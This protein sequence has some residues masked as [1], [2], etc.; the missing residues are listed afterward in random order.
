MPSTT[1][2]STSWSLLLLIL[3]NISSR[4]TLGFHLATTAS[5]I[6]IQRNR[7]QGPFVV[8][9]MIDAEA[10]STSS[11]S[12][13][14]LQTSWNENNIFH[15]LSKNKEN[16]P[17]LIVFDLDNTLWTPELYTLRRRSNTNGI[18][19]P[20]A[21]VHV[22]LFPGALAILQQMREYRND[23]LQPQ[24]NYDS[25][26]SQSNNNDTSNHRTAEEMIQFAIASRTK[27][28]DWAHDLLHQFQIHDL[29]S[30]PPIRNNIF[31]IYMKK[32][33]YRTRI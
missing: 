31:V 8:R 12:S 21:N 29:F 33:V 18:Q 9:P 6:C 14:S 25:N 30:F 28:I 7:Q 32:V 5:S 27:S 13:H 15:A 26:N 20:L 16:I 3:F 24:G 17:K 4:S 10:S 22:T 23:A 19:R 2:T 11:S 1:G